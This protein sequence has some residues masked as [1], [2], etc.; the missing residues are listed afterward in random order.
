MSLYTAPIP[1]PTRVAAAVPGSVGYD[2]GAANQTGTGINPN[3]KLGASLANATVLP[4]SYATIVEHPDFV[5]RAGDVIPCLPVDAQNSSRPSFTTCRIPT[6]FRSSNQR[7]GLLPP[8]SRMFGQI[9][10]GLQAGEERLGILYTLIQTPRFNMPIAAPA[11]DAMGRGGVDGDVHT[12]FWDRAGAVALYALFDMATG[13]GQNLATQSLSQS[14][15]GNNGTNL[16]ITGQSQTLASKEFDATINKPP[17]LT[18]DQA[19][20]VNDFD[21]PGFGI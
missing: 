21:T 14:L 10:S 17:V 5:I 16:N 13:V 20:R 12:F 9:R 8:S 18:R 4:T 6:W 7:R 11:G 2:P 3:D 19:E 15:G 1:V